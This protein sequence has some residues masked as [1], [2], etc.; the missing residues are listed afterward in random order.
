[1]AR[2]TKGNV[3][4]QDLFAD[5]YMMEYDRFMYKD[6][7]AKIDKI[8]GEDLREA[9]GEAK[10]TAAAW[11]SGHLLTSSCSQRMPSHPWPI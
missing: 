2:S 8:T 4:D 11:T 1:M 5:T 6:P 10:E 7:E 9:A 3:K